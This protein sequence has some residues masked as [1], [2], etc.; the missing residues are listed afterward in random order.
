MAAAAAVL[1]VLG[2]AAPASAAWSRPAPG[3][4][5]PQVTRAI[6]GLVAAPRPARLAAGQRRVC[7]VPSRPGQMECMSVIR[8]GAGGAAATTPASAIRG[9]G[10]ASLLSAYN[11]ASASARAGRGKTI[12]L[13]DAFSDPRAAANL[14][15]YRR[16]YK[17]PACTRAS[18]CLRIVNQRGKAGPLPRPN[19]SWALV[20][21]QGLD[22]VS[23]ICPKCRILLVEAASNSIAALGTAENIA[24]AKG[25]KFI[26][27]GWSGTEF[28]GQQAD[29]RFFNHPGVAITFAAG[30]AGYGPAYPTDS[31]YVTAVGG[32]SLSRART[33]RGW[34]ES[35]WSATGSGCSTFAAKP[36]WQRVHATGPAGC[37][38]RAGNDV[39]AVAD[40]NTGVAVFDSFQAGGWLEAGGTSVAATIVAAVYALAGTPAAG[41]YPAAYP[42]RHAAR[43]RPVTAGSNG[44]CEPNRAYL[45]HGEHGYSG[46]GGLGTPHGTAGFSDSG[47]R[48]VTLIDPGTRDVQAGASFALRI[49]GLDADG[50]AASLA[51]Q[52]AGLP[53]GLSIA[54]APHSTDGVITGT[55]PASA[56][57]FAVTVTARDRRTRQAGSTRFSIVAVAS[58]TP[59]APVTAQVRLAAGAGCLDGTTGNSGDS[60]VV[61][62]GCPGHAAFLAWDYIPDGAPGGPGELA[63]AGGGN[64]CLG[65]AG[66]RA[67]LAACA[68]GAA[69]QT[70]AYRNFSQLENP[71]TGRCLGDAHPS[72]GGTQA[73]LLA[74]GGSSAQAWTF[75]SANVLSAIA[76]LCLAVPSGPPPAALEVAAC[77]GATQ[78]TFQFEPNGVIRLGSGCVTGASLR[79]DGAGPF[80]GRCGSGTAPAEIWLNGPDGELINK[81]SG[82]CLADPGNSTVSGTK[83]LLADCYGRPGEIWALS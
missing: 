10:P 4:T 22:M 28:A 9:Y 41:T 63:L 1:G 80:I 82:L 55:L 57:T 45:C 65:L 66:S 76:G 2:A 71:A 30:N 52:A 15:S 36:S 78:Q 42:Y 83:V 37:L 21:A 34:T 44:T 6:S 38:N 53:A 48:P 47:A 35:V 79:R 32:T 64:L 67:R 68:P 81:G 26:S 49:K 43:L 58:M 59:L 51:Y 31:Q 20:E 62:Q 73:S 27:N 17:L 11:L 40:P 74:C 56:R 23:A 60:V 46:P 5:A 7:K 8:T 29:D 33:R 18:G 50:R 3:G 19:A 39:A 54:S 72:V 25:A 61:D 16:H 70:W 69:D 14:A 12:A 77:G 13:V 75:T 24:V